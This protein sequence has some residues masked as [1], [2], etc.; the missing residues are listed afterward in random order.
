MD[1]RPKVVVIGLDGAT[2]DVMRPLMESGDLPHLASLAKTGATEAELTSTFPFVTPT[3]FSSFMTGV[4]PGKHGVFDFTRDGHGTY[5]TGPI[6]NYTHIKARTLWELLGEHGKQST[7]VTVPFTYPP[8]PFNGLMVSIGNMTEGRL[9]TYP[10]ELT[11]E[12]VQNIGGYEERFCKVIR[13]PDGIPSK[14]FADYFIDQTRYQTDKVKQATLYLMQA[15][16]WD[17][18]MTVFVITDRFQHYFWRDMDP[19][20]P[21]H[22]STQRVEYRHMIRDAYRQ[23]DEAVG[24]ILDAAPS[25]SNVIIMS[26]HGFGPLHYVFY[27]NRWLREQGLLEVHPQ[28][29]EWEIR[30]RPLERC[31]TKVGLGMVAR[32]LPGPVGAIPIP[33]IGTR[34]PTVRNERLIDWMQTRAYA[35]KW[36]VNINLKSREPQGIVEP[37]DEYEALVGTIIRKLRLVQDPKT[38]KPLF[39]LVTR[40]E[41]VYHGPYVGEAHDIV[42]APNAVPT[43]LEQSPSY[44]QVIREITGTDLGNGYHRLEGIL[45]MKGPMI[46][47]HAHVGQARLE[48]LAPTILYLLGLPIPDYMDGQVLTSAVRQQVLDQYPIEIVPRTADRQGMPDGHRVESD[49]D[50]ER[51]REQLRSLGYLD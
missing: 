25:D 36:G 3:A 27:T 35:T 18:L 28:K 41:D 12:L 37:G 31:L 47:P 43:E 21:A 8:T 46:A 11:E 44:P 32:W 13:E 49:G 6:V 33:I 45:M 14:T 9:S 40:K 16:P 10:T 17:L 15:H 48:D 50:D 22:H 24:A 20:H 1:Q 39:D 42:I 23:V 51:I 5:D 4:N 29:T 38:G 26:D 7:L 34:S 30:A 2:F 19:A